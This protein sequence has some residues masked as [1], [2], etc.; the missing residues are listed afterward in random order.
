MKKLSTILLALTMLLTVACAKKSGNS[1]DN[2]GQ[3]A[4]EISVV[5]TL[6][7]ESQ[8]KIGEYFYECISLQKCGDV[9]YFFY[10]DL[11]RE[12]KLI[13]LDSEFT[14]SEPISLGKSLALGWGITVHEDGSFTILSPVTD[15]ELEYEDYGTIT[16]YVKFTQ[17][18]SVSFVLT[19][20]DSSGNITGQ[21]DVSGM[22]EYFNIRQSKLSGMYPCGEGEYIVSLGCGAVIL[23]EDGT[24]ADGQVYEQQLA[25]F[26]LDSDG[27][28]IMSMNHGFAYMDGDSLNIP[29]E[30][31]NY[32][33]RL[34]LESSAKTGEMGFK[35]FFSKDD[36][37]YG[38]T[39]DGVLTLVA[40]FRASLIDSSSDVADFVFC[41]DGQFLAAGRERDYLTLHTRRPDDYKE[42][43]KTVDL[44]QIYGGGGD[45]TANTFNKLNDDY[46]VK[47]ALDIKTLE[48]LSEA[49]L[50]GDSPDLIFYTDRSVLDGMINL[51]AAADIYP[52]MESYDGVKA[53]DL[54]PNVLEAFDMDGKLYAIPENFCVLS[55]H[56]NSKV[57]GEEYRN[58]TFDDMYEIYENCPDDMSFADE[59]FNDDLVNNLILSHL[60]PWVDAENSTCNFGSEDFVKL[61]E[62]CKNTQN[63]SALDSGA[64]I[65]AEY[66]KKQL[67]VMDGK[68]AMLS[69]DTGPRYG[70]GQ[71]T[72]TLAG[73]GLLY[74]DAS[75]LNLPGGNGNGVLTFD[76][77]YTI[78]NTGDCPDGAW[79]YVSYLLSDERQ[80]P[81]GEEFPG[82]NWTNKEA[83]EMALHNLITD[84]PKIQKVSA[85]LENNVVF[86]F[87]YPVVITEDDVQR[88]KEF[89]M[90]CTELEYNNFDV[91]GIIWDEY[92]RYRN[93]EITAEECA[94]YIQS[95]VEI[96]LAEQG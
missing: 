6:Y 31:I 71:S 47:M 35:A 37:M 5:Q 29:D 40:D 12:L 38:L 49:A 95:R 27:K 96:L 52:Y 42:N 4:Q 92:E 26:G 16:N 10:E 46:L 73:K 55:W 23:S 41:G 13:K 93:D 39:G 60:T 67:T 30:L 50:T 2:G 59:V 24:V 78:L 87:E 68:Q 84:E 58:W 79:A 9:Y 89:V 44:W 53:D 3:T 66:Y 8:I 36:G 20:Y 61:L 88:Y 21:K 70:L 15:F 62:F 11:K 81:M 57:I 14:V 18:G 83:F 90:N 69:M 80:I 34:M 25:D 56:A 65:D 77:C 17:E 51:G 43:R 91:H 1:L 22:D 45:E 63:V 64:D 72:E 74:S 82:W 33:E 85:S 7:K 94:E 76:N 75:I 19:D 32:E 48:D 86:E 28:L 54:M